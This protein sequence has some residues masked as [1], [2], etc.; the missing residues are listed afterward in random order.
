MMQGSKYFQLFVCRGIG[1]IFQ[2]K[3]RK[4][5]RKVFAVTIIAFPQLTVFKYA[6]EAAI[7]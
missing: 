4:K 5:I 2:G 3:N 6:G 7:A 1:G